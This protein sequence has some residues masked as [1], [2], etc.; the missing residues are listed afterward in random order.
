MFPAPS[1]ATCGE[2]ELSV[3][4]EMLLGCENAWPCAVAHTDDNARIATAVILPKRLGCT[5]SRLLVL[6]QRREE[7]ESLIG[8]SITKMN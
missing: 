5:M 4:L 2:N 1:T 3:L 6:T 8:S 7:P